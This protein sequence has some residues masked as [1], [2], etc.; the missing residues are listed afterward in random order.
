MT[1]TVIVPRGLPA[2]GKSTWVLSMIEQDSN[3]EVVRINNDDLC[4]MLFGRPFV[5][6]NKH[7]A[8]L[9]ANL[10]IALLK[11]FLTDESITDI[12][13]DNTN[14]N[15]RTVRELEKVTLQY[16]ARFIVVDQFLEVPIDVCIERDAARGDRSV[17]PEVLRSMALQANKLQPWKYSA[18]PEIVPYDNDP[19]LP[20]IFLCDIDGTVADKHPDRD[21]YDASKAHMDFPIEPVVAAIKGLLQNNHEIIF[22]SGRSDDSREQTQDWIN[23]NIGYGM[24]LYMR[25]YGDFRPDWIVK[26]ELFQE[27]IAGKYRVV[28][29]FDDRDQVVHLW[30]RRLGLHTMQVND[31]DF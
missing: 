22:M 30:R 9:L 14:L 23:R 7:T 6:K 18:S 13:I 21:I 10:R 24:K 20:P 28:G 5:G 16:G 3:G 12:F 29:V 17:G 15:T 4:T 8:E 1:K 11:Q 31:G 2:S 19:S 27:H 26:H 25:E